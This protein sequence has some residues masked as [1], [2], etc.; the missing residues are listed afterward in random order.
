MESD[1]FSDASV[2][3]PTGEFHVVPGGIL[4]SFKHALSPIF[5]KAHEFN[6]SAIQI[7]VLQPFG[8]FLTKDEP[9]SV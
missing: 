8:L 9:I 5:G 1:V 3:S 2:H 6:R 4:Q 7:E